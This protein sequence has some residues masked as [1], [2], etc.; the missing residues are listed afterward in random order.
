LGLL[1][2]LVRNHYW[3]AGICNAAHQFVRQNHT[4]EKKGVSMLI[5]LSRRNLLR[6]SGA[7]FGACV[8]ASKRAFA[9]NG[10]SLEELSPQRLIRLS[11][12]E[13]PYGPSPNVAEAIQ[14]DFA[15]LNRYADSAAA[16]HFAEQIA[17][18]EHVPERLYYL[19]VNQI[20]DLPAPNR[21][22]LVGS[23]QWISML[24]LSGGNLVGQAG[25]PNFNT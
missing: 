12:N 15:R 23:F 16:Q 6:S 24:A 19:Y 11:F 13:N 7:L 14:H 2:A 1:A 17:S 9:S 25:L 18:Y 22:R 20:N 4:F 8:M 10:S 21:P 3:P 5:D